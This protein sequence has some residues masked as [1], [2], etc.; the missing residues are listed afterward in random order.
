MSFLANWQKFQK[1]S[2]SQLA[3][4]GNKITLTLLLFRSYNRSLNYETFIHPNTPLYCIYSN[5]I[6]YRMFIV[7]L[8]F[9]NSECILHSI[10]YFI[11]YETQYIKCIRT[12]V[13]IICFGNTSSASYK[14]W[15]PIIES[16]KE[17]MPQYPDWIIYTPQHI[18]GYL[19][20]VA[21]THLKVWHMYISSTVP[22]FKMS[23]R[24]NSSIGCRAT[25]PI[26]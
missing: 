13:A 14:I 18:H 11:T 1:Y 22:D 10:S 9:K 26:R 19:S 2:K 5:V 17:A 25:C 7:Y 21:A 4:H 20:Q 8:I 24:P 3:A 12:T 16:N 6:W 23:C 15:N